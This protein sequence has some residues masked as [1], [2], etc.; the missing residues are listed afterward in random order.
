MGILIVMKSFCSYS[1]SDLFL[2]LSEFNVDIKGIKAMNLNVN[3][4]L[5]TP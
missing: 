2:G 5:Y 3:I 1:S 4:I